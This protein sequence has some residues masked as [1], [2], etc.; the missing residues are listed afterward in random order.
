MTNFLLLVATVAASA[1]AAASAAPHKVDNDLEAFVPSAVTVRLAAGASVKLNVSGPASDGDSVLV[2]IDNPDFAQRGDFVAMYLADVD[3]AETVPLKWTYLLPGFPEYGVDGKC[4][5]T[6]QIYNVRAPLQFHL[7]SGTTSSPVML[8]C[9]ANVSFAD[10]GAPIRPRVLNGPT[11]GDFAVAWTTDEASANASHPVLRWGLAAGE[12]TNSSAGVASFVRRADLCGSPA[13]DIG[14]VDLGATVVAQLPGLGAAF[15]GMRVHYALADDE[16]TS[17]DFSFVVPALP[18]AGAF[19]Y[20]F[21]AFGDLGRGSFDDGI[22]WREY[23]APSKNTSVLLAADAAV[24]DLNFIHHFGDISYGCGYLQTWDEYLWMSSRFAA[25]T[26]YLTSYGNHEA[27]APGSSSWSFYGPANDSGGECGVVT[28]ALFPL[29]APASFR[30]PYYAFASG[31]VFLVAMSSEHDF[32]AGSAQLAWLDATLAAVDRAATPFVIVSLHRPMYINSDY[33]ASVPTG[34]VMVMNL[35]QQHVE[36]VTAK[37]RTTLMLYGHN[38]RLERISAAFQ[39]KTVTASVPVADGEGGVVHVFNKPG[40]TVHYV[41]GTAG[42]NYTPNDC[43]S[44]GIACP[45]WSEAVI[46]EHGYLRFEALNT[47]ALR[48]DYIA[49]V[50]GSVIDSVL[51]LQ[52]LSGAWAA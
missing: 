25:Q 40:A 37:H 26:V 24:G 48:F 46:F 27:D 23:G 30:A 20:R 12:Y 15:A 47:T 22:T 10:D 31:P 42:A 1:T 29:P 19:P 17:E 9:S 38:H 39:N 2:Q 14:F 52:D 34:D 45:E 51:I 16:R 7:F 18:G 50:N 4:N 6:F 32:T 43:V 28:A 21:A 13:V 8:A 11:P 49:S 36:P 35:L 44:V 3:P 33:G 5:L 41:A